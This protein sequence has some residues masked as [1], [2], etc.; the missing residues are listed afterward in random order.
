MALA[1]AAVK[2]MQQL[3]PQVQPARTAMRFPHIVNSLAERWSTPQRCREYFDRLLI[4]RRGDRLG[5]PKAIGS[6]LAALKDH[7][8]SVVDPTA[9]TVWDEIASA[10]RR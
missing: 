10:A 8:D 4:D 7:Y 2:W 5:F 9:Q 6:E 3:P 1:D